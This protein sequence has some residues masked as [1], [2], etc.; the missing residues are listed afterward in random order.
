MR[1]LTEYEHLLVELVHF[2]SHG[3]QEEMGLTLKEVKSWLARPIHS[4]G[5]INALEDLANNKHE[6]L[7]ELHAFMENKTGTSD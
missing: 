3:T 5:G 1:E 4:K 6:L 7:K 2:L